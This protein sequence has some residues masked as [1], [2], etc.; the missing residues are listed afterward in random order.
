[1]KK[2]LNWLFKNFEDSIAMEESI[3]YREE[4]VGYINS[5]KGDS[6]DGIT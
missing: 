6:T 4:Q 5:L 3:G 2:L 1:M